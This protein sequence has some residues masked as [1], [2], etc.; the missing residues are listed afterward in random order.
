M[1]PIDFAVVIILIIG[2]IWGFAKGFVYTIFSLLAIAGGVFGASK[3]TSIVL[4]HLFSEK[5]TQV[6][7][8]IIF[9]LIFTLIYFIIRKISYIFEDMIA[10]LELE[11]LD[12]LLGG[13]IGLFQFLIIIGI[14]T[15]LT[16]STGIIRFIPQYQEIKFTL[17]V[18]DF[19]QKIISL[20]MGNLNASNFRV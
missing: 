7:Y 8:I 5:Y 16:Y 4:P 12:S 14:L 3:L 19:S 17:L 15:S 2:F 1:N 9:I 11:W 10:F 13:F 20:L 6:G 18:S